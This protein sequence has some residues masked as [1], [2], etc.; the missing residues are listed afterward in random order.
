MILSAEFNSV[1]YDLKLAFEPV[2]MNF[3][4]SRAFPMI[5]DAFEKYKV[6]AGVREY[7]R[8]G[9]KAGF[10]VSASFTIVPG[11]RQR[12]NREKGQ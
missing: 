11:D 8:F 4:L 1:C 6:D 10:I 9:F 2:N 3:Q 12:G 7:Q 5:N